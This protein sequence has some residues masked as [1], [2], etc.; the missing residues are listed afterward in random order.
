MPDISI[1]VF[2]QYSKENFKGPKIFVKSM[3]W[4]DTI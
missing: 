1:D 2:V 4:H 3:F